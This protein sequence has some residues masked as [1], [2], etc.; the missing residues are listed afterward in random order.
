[1]S[2]C[3]LVLLH[4]IVFTNSFSEMQM[5]KDDLQEAKSLIE[6]ALRIRIKHYGTEH[7]LVARCLQDLAIIADNCGFSDK[8]IELSNRAL[9]IREKVIFFAIF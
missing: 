9:S 5:R 8:A 4:F 3:K 1:M 6:R 2:V 7:P